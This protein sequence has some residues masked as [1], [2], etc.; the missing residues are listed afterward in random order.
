M[1]VELPMPMTRQIRAGALLVGGGEGRAT[2]AHGKTTWKF[3]Q[4]RLT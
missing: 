2:P 4:R 1:V 3:L